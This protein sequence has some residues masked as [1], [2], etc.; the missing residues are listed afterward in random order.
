[1]STRGVAEA[2]R[3][4]DSELVGG[5]RRG[6]PG[7]VERLVREHGPGLLALARS[8]TGCDQQG[9]DVVQEAIVRALRSIGTLE[10]PEALRAWLHRITANVALQHL[11]ARKR[12]RERPI[13]D[14]LP[15]FRNDGH[16]EGVRETWVRDEGCSLEREELL[17]SV[18]AAVESLPPTYREIVMLR[19]L[20]GFDTAEAA[21]ALGIS[22]NLAK[23]RLHRARQALRSLLGEE[24][25]S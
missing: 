23:V 8:L 2:S 22:P 3:Q 10:R 11:R 25:G 13:G 7:A 4:G 20:A 21:E 19:D 6:E 15:V 9:Q 12:R 1:M 18:R 24:F 5:L 17:E 16:R 14:L